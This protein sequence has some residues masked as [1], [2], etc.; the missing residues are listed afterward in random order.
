[1]VHRLRPVFAVVHDNAVPVV[2]ETLFPGDL[3]RGVHQVPEHGL[4]VLFGFAELGKAP[5]ALGDDEDVDRGLRC[6]V[7]EGHA[8]VV[9]V[10][11]FATR[12][13]RGVRE[14]ERGERGKKGE[15]HG[16][17]WGPRNTHTQSIESHN[18]PA[19]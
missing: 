14:E 3:R 15:S 4:V 1:M 8:E 19:T 16:E 13:G 11:L 18:Q 2:R 6:D 17:S 12:D 10:H 7:A 9:L 5:L